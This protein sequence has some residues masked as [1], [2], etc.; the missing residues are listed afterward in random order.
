MRGLTKNCIR[1]GHTTYILTVIATTRLNRPRVRCSE[2]FTKLKWCAPLSFG[3]PPH[4]PIDK[5][6]NNLYP[7]LDHHCLRQDHTFLPPFPINDHKICLPTLV[8]PANHLTISPVQSLVK[9]LIRPQGKLEQ[10][11]RQLKAEL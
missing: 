10:I 2:N 4:S 8:L 9:P 6:T 5:C 1:R 7:T 11:E 3:H